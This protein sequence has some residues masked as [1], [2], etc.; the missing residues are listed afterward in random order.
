MLTQAQLEVLTAC[1]NA[2]S[3]RPRPLVPLLGVLAGDGE[4]PDQ[5]DLA[6]H[7]RTA[8]QSDQ[9]LNRL[10]YLLVGW[11]AS[12]GEWATGSSRNTRQRR[13]RIYDMLGLDR[14]LRAALDERLPFA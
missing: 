9:V 2:L 1:F 10:R 11:D 6:T 4:A 5:S 13:E 3:E 7:V 8:E 12:D 14:P